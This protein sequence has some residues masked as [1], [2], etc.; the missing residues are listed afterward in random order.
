MAK[1]NLQPNEGVILK[2][3]S[4]SHGFWGGYTDE[5]LLTNLNFVWTSIGIM[6]FPQKTH[7]YPLHQI[8]VY[9]GR[10]QVRLG[11]H[12][13]NGSPMLEISF[14]DGTEESFGFQI[15][16]KEATKEIL[17]WTK[18][19]NKAVTG[20][21]IDLDPEQYWN[22]NADQDPEQDEDEDTD[23]SVLG[24]FREIGNELKEAIIG[25]P[26]T[27]RQKQSA[28]LPLEQQIDTLKKLK[29]LLDAGILSQKEFDAKKK[30]IMRL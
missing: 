18:A 6:G 14:M 13:G 3:K 28:T 27:A 9:D 10:A 12:S 20:K 23:D 15:S 5:I 25:T 21:D 2:S 11:E 24:A 1:Y 4:V 19:I 30:E 17:R 16:D 26:K 29:E 7:Q 8:K 22:K